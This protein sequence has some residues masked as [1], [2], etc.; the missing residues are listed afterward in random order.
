MISTLAE[1]TP[2]LF[3]VPRVLSPR[4]RWMESH[5]VS[6]HALEGRKARWNGTFPLSGGF[7]S[8]PDKTYPDGT[9]RWSVVVPADT[10][11]EDA[12]ISLALAA[13]ARLWN[14]EEWTGGVAG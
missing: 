7:T 1:D 8:A 4:I 12:L 13:G 9:A 6:T 2:L 14:E 3:E 10:H 11:E 5:R